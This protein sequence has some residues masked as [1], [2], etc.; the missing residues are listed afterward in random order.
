MKRSMQKGFTLIELMIVV[1][2]IGILA[3]VALPAY[4]DYTNKAKA[5][6]VSSLIGPAKTAI[7]EFSGTWSATNITNTTLNLPAAADIN[8]NYVA[9]V[10]VVGVAADD[11]ATGIGGTATITATFKAASSTV[12]AAIA[13]KTV[14]ILATH[15]A[16]SVNFSID[17]S[18]TLD[19]KYRPKI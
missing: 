3:A 11:A 7:G 6:E 18:S 4:Q 19:A 17:G 14:V 10:A 8:G 9:S 15:G 12:P 16:G 2:I 1:A 5:S 13:G